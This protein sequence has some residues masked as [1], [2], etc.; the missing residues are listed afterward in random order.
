MAE[1]NRGLTRAL[2]LSIALIGIGMISAALAVA[3]SPGW[4]VVAYGAMLGLLLLD[5]RAV[6]KLRAAT[7]RVEKLSRRVAK[8]SASNTPNEPTLLKSLDNGVATILARL[9]AKPLLAGS[10]ADNSPTSD[11][12]IS[13]RE[14]AR[15][16]SSSDATKVTEYLQFAE[17]YFLTRLAANGAGAIA[18][19]LLGQ[20]R[21]LDAIAATVGSVASVRVPRELGA[22]AAYLDPS[23]QVSA[24][25]DW[26]LLTWA[27]DSEEPNSTRTT[28]FTVVPTAN[29]PVSILDDPNSPEVHSSLWGTSLRLMGHPNTH[30]ETKK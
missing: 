28:T 16:G 27:S 15:V 20:L 11:A 18:P 3:W 26:V 13:P 23:V 17:T 8:P 21:E 4:A 9:D 6:G 7:A 30:W 10:A 25:G 12:R 2:L 14:P 29:R 1:R 24:D 19:A 22:H 5:L